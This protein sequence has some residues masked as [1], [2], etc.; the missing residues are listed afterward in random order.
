MDVREQGCWLHAYGSKAPDMLSR[1]FL[2]TDH[3]NMW[4]VPAAFFS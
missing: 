3:V 1:I 2:L 4:C